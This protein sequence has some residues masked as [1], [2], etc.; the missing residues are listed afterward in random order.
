MQSQF[1][2]VQLRVNLS[3]HART[4]HGAEG[5]HGNPQYKYYDNGCVIHV[6]SGEGNKPFA[7]LGR[8]AR[9]A[10]K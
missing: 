9:A 4:I 3:R 2:D 10:H 1:M 7:I 5:F 8:K 6:T